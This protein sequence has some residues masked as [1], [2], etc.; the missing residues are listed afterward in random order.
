M[1]CICLLFLYIVNTQQWHHFGKGTQCSTMENVDQTFRRKLLSTKQT[2]DLFF[3]I[4]VTICKII[5]LISNMF[6]Q[7]ICENC[8]SKIVEMYVHASDIYPS[9]LVFYTRQRVTIYYDLANRQM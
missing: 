9:A 6:I 1:T 4:S 7:C 8:N 5:V 3:L 2:F